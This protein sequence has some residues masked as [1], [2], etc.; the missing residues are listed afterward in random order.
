MAV[1]AADQNLAPEPRQKTPGERYEALAFTFCKTAT[2][3]LLTQKFAL[4]V[5][6]GL[7]AVFYILAQVHGKQDTRCILKHPVLIAAFWGSIA[8]CSLILQLWPLFHP[9]TPR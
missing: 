7:A 4:P 9:A 2:L 8:V 6:A 3:V 1:T 5:S